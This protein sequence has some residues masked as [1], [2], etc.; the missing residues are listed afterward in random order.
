MPRTRTLLGFIE[1]IESHSSQCFGYISLAVRTQLGICLLKGT[2]DLLNGVVGNM[3]APFA[4]VR[5]L[6][7]S[8]AV[9]K[10]SASGAVCL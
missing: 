10:A 9:W 4:R 3:L 8:E 2:Q 1:R 5:K 6:Y 7:F